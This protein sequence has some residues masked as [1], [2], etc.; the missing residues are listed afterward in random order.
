MLCATATP[1]S[2]KCAKESRGSYNI[3]TQRI[4]LLSNGTITE[5]V[6]EQSNSILVTTNPLFPLG[7][8]KI[9]RSAS[10]VRVLRSPLSRLLVNSI[11]Q[12]H[13]EQKNLSKL[14]LAVTSWRNGDKG[15]CLTDGW[16]WDGMFLLEGCL[17]SAMRVAT[18]LGGPVPWDDMYYEWFMS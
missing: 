9:I 2:I 14:S 10:F 5:A 15:V 17:V 1:N 7:K 4:H 3:G 16:C 18:D 11:F 6:H 13:G 8:S 12:G